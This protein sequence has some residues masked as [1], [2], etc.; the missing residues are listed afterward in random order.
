VGTV[1]YRF[2]GRTLP[3]PHTTPDPVLLQD[4]FAQMR[5]AGIT[6]VAMEVSSHALEQRRVDGCQFRAAA[7]TNLTQDHLDFHGTME[8]YFA[9]KVRL[10][11]EL[12]PRSRAQAPTAVVSLDDPR[13]PDVAAICKT[14]VLT[15]S[16]SDPKADF[17]AQ[18]A[19]FSSAG[20]S[21]TLATPAGPIEVRSPLVGTY[22]LQNI[23]F[24]TGLALSLGIGPV[25]IAA[26]LATCRGAPGRLERVDND[27]G[28]GI[29]VDY[30][31][32]GDALLR[33]LSAV[34]QQTTGRLIAVFGCGGDRDRTKRPV[35]GEVAARNADLVVVT[36]DNPRTED[37]GAIIEMILPG[38]RAAGARELPA[39]EA[40]A[41]DAK[42]F[43]VEP[44]RRRAIRLAIGVAR[45]GDSVVIAGKGHEDYQILGRTRVHF[46]DRE[47][48]RA[49]LEALR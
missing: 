35:M 8:A 49:A 20:I 27:R 47:E 31:H 19:R 32:T 7:F 24:A 28:I 9:S 48:A 22:N 43:I 4:L 44:D 6:H 13:G 41:A 21:A 38:L 34:R 3:A 18:G 30:A 29:F 17:R 26:A 2:A 11:E 25:P 37:P 42:G 46:D 39:G 40:G 36:S 45:A 10:F 15:Y 16:L 5:D 14:A 12:L 23:L 1:G 33:V